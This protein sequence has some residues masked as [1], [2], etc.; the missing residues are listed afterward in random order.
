[1]RTF[2][3]FFLIGL[4]SPIHHTLHHSV[5]VYLHRKTGSR[6]DQWWTVGDAQE[7]TYDIRDDII[8]EPLGTG[9]TWD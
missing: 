4:T 3:M 5:I 6:V 8:D 9:F 2:P 1:M 7:I